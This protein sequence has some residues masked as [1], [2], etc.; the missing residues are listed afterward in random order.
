MKAEQLESMKRLAE[1][2][3]DK[4]TSVPMSGDDVF[5]A[6]ENVFNGSPGCGLVAKY[7]PYDRPVTDPMKLLD[8]LAKLDYDKKAIAE[9]RAYFKKMEELKDLQDAAG[10]ALQTLRSENWRSKESNMKNAAAY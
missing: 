6:L 4:S 9:L 1:G 8:G 7:S 5:R 3:P 10:A 2:K